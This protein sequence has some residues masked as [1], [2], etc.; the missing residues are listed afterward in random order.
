MS[1]KKKIAVCG[2]WHVHAYEYSMAA[3]DFAE[4]T[5]VW[6]SDAERRKSFCAQ[7]GFNEYESFEELLQSDAEGV[8][9]TSATSEHEK[10]IEAVA[11]AGKNI[12]CEK[13]LAADT[14]ICYNIKK[15]IEKYGVDFVI[16]LFRKFESL[17]LTVKSIVDS[18]E[19]GKLNY[20]RFRNCHNGS[21]THWLP[22]QFFNRDE[23][24]GGSLM[25]LGAHGMYLASWIMGGLPDT[26]SSSL[27][28]CF[29]D[30]TQV[31]DNAVAVMG[32]KNGA[33]AVNE[34]SFVSNCCP[35][36]ME[37]GGE[38][39]YVYYKGKGPVIK[40]TVLTDY[41]PCEVGLCEAKPRPIIQFLTGNILD[42]C[43]ID[44]AIE[45]TK[46]MEG[47]YAAAARARE[48]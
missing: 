40:S 22:A 24:C 23:C 14:A 30:K 28:Y 33:I 16:S 41:K 31:E 2:V 35:I 37:V 42:G 47:A 4:V 25:D 13:V 1:E 6:D 44:D 15:T 7:H 17:P 11:A 48:I 46:M 32:Y 19:L 43:G 10:Y 34:A 3:K 21:S 12:F 39:G 20:F 27:G 38:N 5:G 45:L 26:Y 9:L 18:G 8:I 36:T 29:T